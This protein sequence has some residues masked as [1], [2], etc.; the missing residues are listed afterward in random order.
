MTNTS[1]RSLSLVARLAVTIATAFLLMQDA[2]TVGTFARAEEDADPPPPPVAPDGSCPGT[3]LLVVVGPRR[4]AT[5]SVAEFFYK[6]ARGS[7]FGRASGKIYHPLAKFRW[8]MVYGV[9][10]NKTEIDRPYKRFNHLVTDPDNEP[11]RKEIIDAIVADYNQ[12]YVDAVIFGGEEFDQVGNIAGQNNNHA[13]VRAIRD[14]QE[15]TG[16]PDECVTI[17][18]NY[19]VPRFEHWVSLYSSK[20]LLES[21][22][23]YDLVDPD[24]AVVS[25]QFLP[26]TEHMCLETSTWDR[27]YEL[28]TSMN[29]MYLA[30]IYLNPTNGLG[31]GWK[32]AMVDMGGV[33]KV[34]GDITHTI[35]CEILGGKCTEDSRWVKGHVQESFFNAVLER[36]YNSLPEME[37]D[38]S[39]QLFLYRDCAYQRDL[40]KNER[41]SIVRQ[42]YIWKNCNHDDKEIK[43]I[44]NSLRAPV[45]GTWLVYDALL[46]QVDCSEYGD[47]SAVP[48]NSM[49][50]I[51]DGIHLK[52]NGHFT[53][54]GMED[55]F[56]EFD[57]D[58]GD[59]H[60]ELSYVNLFLLLLLLTCT[61][62]CCRR[63]CKRRRSSTGY[64]IPRIEMKNVGNRNRNGGGG[65]G[66]NH[67]RNENRRGGNG[68]GNKGGKGY[69]D[70]LKTMYNSEDDSGSDDD[71]SSDGSVSS[72]S[73]AEYGNGSGYGP[74][75]SNDKK[76]VGGFM[77]R[78]KK[79]PNGKMQGGRGKSGDFI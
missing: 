36:D 39:E 16:A 45:E 12:D 65:G 53:F 59:Y 24:N 61:S 72:A 32:V 77:S 5:S 73:S 69:R 70:Q 6:Y 23:D 76:G 10:S 18:I 67:G 17:V 29:P 2:S 21:G 41:F 51:L 68:N 19:R 9:E 47:E 46:S 43:S 20:T 54:N 26:Y 33:N 52:K 62:C 7:Q 1:F 64:S 79:N 74:D 14:V 30:E 3:R 48:S 37:I 63:W 13:A 50:D 66:R 22:E 75:G 44:Y 4:S 38:N 55:K 58:V 34:D 27:M 78:F 57:L 49:E 35:G 40:Q 28:L 11:L 8:P 60:G 25:N 31:E 56:G 15:A 42:D 71:S